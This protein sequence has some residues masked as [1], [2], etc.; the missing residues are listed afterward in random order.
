[1]IIHGLADDNVVVAHSLRLSSALLA[2]GRPHRVLP[3]SGVTHMASQEEVAENLL[4]LQ[5]DFLR[6]ALGIQ[7]RTGMLPGHEQTADRRL[8]R[9]QGRRRRH[10]RARGDGA[11]IVATVPGESPSWIA[12]HPELPVLYAVEET[13]EGR[14]HA[15]PLEDGVPASRS[16][17]GETG[18]SEPAHLAV[19]STG[20]FLITA[21]YSGGSISVHRLRRGRQHRRAHRPGPARAARRPSAARSRRTRTW[22]APSTDGAARHRPR[23]RR[24]LPVPAA[25]RRHA[26]AGQRDRRAAWLWPAARAPVGDR[27]YVTAELSGRVA[28][29]RDRRAAGSASCRPAR[30]TAPTSRRSWPATASSSTSPTAGPN[31]VTCSRSD[32]DRPAAVRHRGPGRRL[33]P[34]HRPGRRH[35]VCGERAVARGHGACASTRTPASRRRCGR[36]RCR[37]RPSCCPDGRPG[38]A[39]ARDLG[40]VPGKL[41]AGPAN[42]ISD[43]PG[44]RVGHATLIAGT[45]I[46]PTGVTA[47]V[48]DALLSGGGRRLPAGLAVFNGFGKMAGAT[49]LAELGM[50][51]T[52]V[53]LTA[54]CRCSGSPTRCS[55]TARAARR[56]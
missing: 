46:S 36:S 20:R 40:L 38:R 45:D 39:R 54:L 49:Q 51:E 10:H 23:R 24:D 33:A 29:L 7:Q 12:R 2:A 35:A 17:R 41:P 6:S 8:L 28:G 13:D 32:S 53:L 1:M 22:S 42:A 21:N 30:R 14:V 11:A 52:P 48:H 37:A 15:W 47:I 27:Y 50:L 43:V 5:V 3:L 16:A 55:A 9:G 56:R 44:I 19:D 18:G 4:L 25:R 34:A 31:T 26:R